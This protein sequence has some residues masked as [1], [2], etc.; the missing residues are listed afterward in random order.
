VEQAVTK[1]RPA[2]AAP[3]ATQAARTLH[4]ASRSPRRRQLLDEAALDHAAEHPGFDDSD[5]SP[6]K[7]T[8]SQWVGALA[9]L[10]AAAGAAHAAAGSTV[11]GADTAIIKDGSLI[12]TPRD[13]AEAFRILRT[14]S[15]GTH[16][17]VTGVALL[18]PA[19]GRRAIFVDRAS[20]TVGHLS[21]CMISAYLATGAWQ[22][23]AGGY[24]LRERLV[25]G[26]PLQFSG[27]PTTV[28]GL[29]MKALS[30][31]LE[32]FNAACESFSAPEK[33]PA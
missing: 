15:D 18:D 5:L 22:G 14:L 19:T 11:L 23:K 9:Y 20:V 21:D 7:V 16:D 2:G 31:Q 32:Q 30:P 25:D 8:A 17:V 13:H 1:T 24:N 33:V 28:M 10:K 4:L 29:P 26:W 12:G 6:G 3:P 27:D